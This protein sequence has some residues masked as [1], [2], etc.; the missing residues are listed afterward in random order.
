[1]DY[2][3]FLVS[4]IREELDGGRTANEAVTAGLATTGKMIL[5]AGIIMTSV[6]S[7]FATNP[8]PVI[9]QIAFGLAFAIAVDAV[10]I[11]LAVVPA[12]LHVFGRHTWWLPRPLERRLPHLEVG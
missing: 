2:E 12:W 1:M 10:I 7:A 6:F 9:K 4:R 11:R 8:S 5:A 3:V